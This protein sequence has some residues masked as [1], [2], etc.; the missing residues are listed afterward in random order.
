MKPSKVFVI[1]EIEEMIKKNPNLSILDLGSGKSLNFENILNKYPDIKYVG[2]EPNK[3]EHIYAKEKFKNHKNANF[4]NG[5]AYKEEG[6]PE[7]YDLVIS[8]S[9]LEHVKN[10]EKF[11]KFSIEKTKNGGKCI[12]LYDLGHALY[13]HSLKEKIHVFLCSN[14]LTRKYVPETKF[15]SYV[16]SDF[17]EKTLEKFGGTKEKI[18]YHNSP[19]HVEMI[20]KSNSFTREEVAEL[21]QKEI[22][23]S[24]KIKDKKIKEKLFP[25]IC[26]WFRKT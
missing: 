20:K 21:A 5:L 11:L 14:K 17:A 7:E 2:L 9:V 12:H 25:S 6:M 10:L 15:V 4:V 8:L 1:D 24:Q 26:L 23:W 3:E 13:P 22:E 19:N 16:G 18:T